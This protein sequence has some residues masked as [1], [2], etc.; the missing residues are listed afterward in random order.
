LAEV[1][2]QLRAFHAGLDPARRR[3][4]WAAIVLSILTVIGVGVWASQPRYVSLVTTTDPE[5]RSDITTALSRASIPWRLGAD[6]STIE[7]LESDETAARSSSA[8]EHGIL[9][10]EGLEQLDP[11][12]TPFVETLQKQRMLQG[13]IVRSLN[14]MEGI[15][16]SAVILNIPPTSEF[17]G[18][19]TRATAAVTLTPDPGAV[20]GRET[21]K[22]VAA[23]VSHA[24]SGMTP[25]DVS[26]SDTSTGRILWDGGKAEEN[27]ADALA[28]TREAALSGKLERVLGM[29][30]GSP[31][32]FSVA[33]MVEV[34]TATTE[35]TT[36]S[37]DPETAAPSSE[38]IESEANS[39]NSQ[40]GAPGTDSNLPERSN[41]ANA[42]SRSRERQATTYLYTRTETTT[43]Q[44]AGEVQRMSA[45]VLIDKAT[46]TKV[47]GGTLDE[48][49]E[50]AKL[51][52]L[53]K[54][55]LGADASRG[56][57][58]VVQIVPFADTGAPTEEPV[59][60]PTT[61][62]WEKWVP[63][64]IAALAVAII[65]L[66]VIRPLVSAAT[67]GSRAAEAAAKAEAEAKI[68]AAKAEAEAKIAEAKAA[69]LDV[70]IGD[71][72]PTFNADGTPVEKQD[73]AG[74]G[75]QVISLADRLRKQIETYKH[76]STEDLSELVRQETDSSA[77][78]L[79]RWMQK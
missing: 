52:A 41:G 48:A 56:D 75:A 51:E 1:I 43:S 23:F 14:R 17:I 13:E 72:A 54:G 4:L 30:L 36:H 57:V 5:E 76:I 44:P 3:T 46:L 61:A 35:S 2:A 74:E 32:A 6:G 64:A 15:S 60:T 73:E 25:D 49:A 20:L 68:I 70:A 59:E 9:G 19:T 69:K 8:G 79:R 34:S 55:A 18:R 7:V 40:T 24:V 66:F 10:L 42:E 62:A 37:V 39:S 50:K 77:E 21:A 33:V 12:A 22:A 11:W 71:E 47:V 38:Q 16:R 31:T 63:T 27:G 28:N 65:L 29:M 58:V 78:V 67:A 26:V 53:V 45:T